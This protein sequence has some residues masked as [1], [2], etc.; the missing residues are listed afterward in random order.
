ML[1][2]AELE[3]RCVEHSRARAVGVFV[4]VVVV[5]VAVL[6]VKDEDR[7]GDDVDDDG[8]R[9]V[10]EVVFRVVVWWLWPREDLGVVGVPGVRIHTH[11]QNFRFA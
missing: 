6:V 8:G 5:V 1:N 3:E 4:V 2:R 9:V 11:P 10:V 7:G